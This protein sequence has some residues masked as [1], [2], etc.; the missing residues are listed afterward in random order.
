[1]SRKDRRK[2]KQIEYAQKKNFEREF[3]NKCSELKKLCAYFGKVGCLSLDGYFLATN[4]E[5]KI[6]ISEN[7][8]LDVTDFK[9]N[10]EYV[11]IY[12]EFFK[13]M[14]GVRVFYL[15]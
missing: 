1:M 8:G 7:I 9:A 14:N 3:Q 11:G 12:R 15:K 6:H 2:K 4:P 13:D 10:Y 5:I